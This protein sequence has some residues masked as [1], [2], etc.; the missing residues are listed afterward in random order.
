MESAEQEKMSRPFNVPLT[1]I[2]TKCVERLE[3][4]MAVIRAGES[5][6]TKNRKTVMLTSL[7]W[8]YLILTTKAPSGDYH[9]C[10]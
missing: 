9:A 7:P 3:E 5:D 4:L 10:I 6:W 2:R 1:G 8:R